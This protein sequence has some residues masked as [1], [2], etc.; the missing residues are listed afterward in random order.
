MKW[1]KIILKNYRMFQCFINERELYAIAR[2]SVVCHLSVT[3]VHPTQAVEIFSNIYTAFGT[4]AICLHP[5]KI[6]ME[7]VPGKPLRRGS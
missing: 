1:N 7:I 6:F 5:R 2:P 4:F 3:F